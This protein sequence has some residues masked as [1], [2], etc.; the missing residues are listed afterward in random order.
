MQTH[1]RRKRRRNTEGWRQGGREGGRSR[2]RQREGKRE[3]GG[4][5][6]VSLNTSEGWKDMEWH[7]SFP[8]VQ[9]LVSKL[10]INL[11][12]VQQLFMLRRNKRNNLKGKHSGVDDYF[13]HLFLYFSATKV[14]KKQK[15]KH[16]AT[17]C[18]LFLFQLCN[19]ISE[20]EKQRP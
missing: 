1:T 14:A 6:F 12:S 10:Q 11:A 3:G 13:V 20:I 19:F 8:S 4:Q 17:S 5:Y 16:R 7:F 2:R 18:I 15:T 9:S